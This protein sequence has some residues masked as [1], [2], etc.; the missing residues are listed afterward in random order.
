M[1][2]DIIEGYVYVL[3]N[4]IYDSYGEIYKIGQ[5]KNINDR[6][7]SYST[8]Y[9]EESE[10]KYSIKHPYYKELEKV[11][12]L[13]L[14]EHR[15]SSNREF[16]KCSLDIIKYT[17]DKVKE[18]TLEE[19]SSTLKKGVDIILDGYKKEE[20]KE[21]INLSRENIIKIFNENRK[22]LYDLFFDS[23]YKGIKSIVKIFIDKMCTNKDGKLLISCIDK[24]KHKYKYTDIYNKEVVITSLKICNLLLACFDIKVIISSYLLRD[25]TLDEHA[26]IEHRKQ[27]INGE[28]KG[29]SNK[30]KHI[31]LEYF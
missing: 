21:P 12:H 2:S 5:A 19:I 22:E 17:I 1:S 15:M 10:I 23:K 6:L 20:V 8:S 29:I 9:P 7:K 11:V 28:F 4:P 27:Y 31:M 18:Y 14:K 13:T 25:E 30:F 3:Y 24:T 26:L 16:F